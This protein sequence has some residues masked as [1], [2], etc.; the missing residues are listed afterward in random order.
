MTAIELKKFLVHQI[1]EIDDVSFLN[2]LKTILETKTQSQIYR[3]SPEERFEI[4]ESRNEIEQGQYIDQAELE[5][6]FN[7]WLSE[8]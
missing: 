6:E 1:A 3:L 7:A 8:R 5:K 4:Q 2:A